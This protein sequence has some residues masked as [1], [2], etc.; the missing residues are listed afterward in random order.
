MEVSDL[1][2]VDHKISPALCALCEACDLPVVERDGVVEEGHVCGVCH[3][4]EFS[5]GDA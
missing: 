3:V 1:W 5:E 2:F 4:H